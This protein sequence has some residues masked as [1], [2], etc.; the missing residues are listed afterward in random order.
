MI[1]TGMTTKNWSSAEQTHNFKN[2]NSQTMTP[3]ERD[4]ALQGRDLGTVLNE[5]TDP[6]YVD[7]SKS[8]RSAKTELGKD[9]FFKL[10]LAQIKN[11][12]P[13]NPMQSHEMAA[14]LAQFTSLEQ[15]YNVNENLASLKKGQDPMAN[16]QALNFIG[17]TVA[18]DG[19]RVIRTK[20]DTKHEVHYSIP[21]NA[22]D[23]N[24]TIS[25]ATGAEVRKMK[26]NNVKLGDVRFSWNGLTNDGSVATAGEYSVKIEAKDL[27]NKNI[28]VK[29][30]FSGRVTGVNFANGTPVLMIGDQTIRLSDIKK[31]EDDQL[32]TAN[33]QMVAPSV[34]KAPAPVSM[35]NALAPKKTQSATDMNKAATQVR[36]QGDS[37]PGPEAGAAVRSE[38]RDMVNKISKNNLQQQ[39]EN[40][41]ASSEEAQK[42]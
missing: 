25:D 28:A 34:G 3:A 5:V 40:E 22:K 12:D 10:M 21:A 2:D 8:P 42:L 15:L 13:T 1:N 14:H 9:A 32:K 4:A 24:V 16:Y 7:P 33:D 38:L 27:N 17:K 26:F 18:S 20:G 31:I 19:S 39:A 11:Q 6:N 35:G 29:T 37:E 36:K 23:V 41:K 30:N